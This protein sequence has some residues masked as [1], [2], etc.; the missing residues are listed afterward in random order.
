MEAPLHS[1]AKELL[2]SIDDAL[3]V[4]RIGPGFVAR[5]P[6]VAKPVGLPPWFID[7][8]R[9][10]YLSAQ[11]DADHRLIGV[12]SASHG[13]GKTSVAIGIATAIAA[14][15]REPTLLLECEL[16]RPS[17]CRFFGVPAERGL[18]EWLDNTAALRVIRVPYMPQLVVIPAGAPHP[19]PARLLYQITETNV[20]AELKS[21]FRNIVLDLPPMLDIAYSSL[22][23][24]L[25]ERILVVARYGETPT[26]DLERLI[27]L[28]GRER[29]SGL[30]LNGTDFRT[31]GWLRR[32]L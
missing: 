8:C 3:E 22:A 2:E 28:L 10:A 9:R 4:R 18:T 12:T 7:R 20:I 16:E 21:R 6:E 5:P 29:I 15:T 31:P 23:S 30:V 13:E 26:E 14:D 11:L 24:R 27:F 25:A 32:L 17:F 19:D 1:G